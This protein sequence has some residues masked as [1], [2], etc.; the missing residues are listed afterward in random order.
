[1]TT[2]PV[3]KVTCDCGTTIREANDEA[4]VVAVQAHAKRVH[5]MEMT[6]EQVLSMAEPV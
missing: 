6:P 1:M 5:Q 2:Q 4:L 3:K